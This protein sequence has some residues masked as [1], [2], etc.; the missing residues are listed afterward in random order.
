MGRWLMQVVLVGAL[1]LRK[2]IDVDAR[3]GGVHVA[4]GAHDDP[5]AVDLF[6]DAVTTGD[7]DGA[8]VHGHDRLH[9]GADQR[10]V[11]LHQRHGL[12]LHVGA[13]QR[14]VGVVVLQER[15]QGSSDRNELFRRH[16]HHVH[17]VRAFRSWDS[18]LIRPGTRSSTICPS[19]SSMLAWAIVYFDSSM[20]EM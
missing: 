17:G 3:T 11:R 10:R 15:D 9:A 2:A 4:G 7:H 6:D 20:A 5:G 16:V 19:F 1:E 8:G 18:P 13:H 14:A 12:T